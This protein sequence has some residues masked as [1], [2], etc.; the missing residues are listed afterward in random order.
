M[1]RRH[2]TVIHDTQDAEAIGRVLDGQPHPMTPCGEHLLD[3][4]SPVGTPALARALDRNPPIVV[5]LETD[6]DPLVVVREQEDHVL[7]AEVAGRVGHLANEIVGVQAVGRQQHL[8]QC[9]TEPVVVLFFHLASLARLEQSVAFACHLR[10]SNSEAPDSLRCEAGMRAR[11]DD[12]NVG[13]KRGTS[14]SNRLRRGPLRSVWHWHQHST[15]C[16]PKRAPRRR[17]MATARSDCSASP[18]CSASAAWPASSVVTGTTTTGTT[19]SGNQASLADSR[20]TPS[21][22]TDDRE[23][24]SCRVG[25]R[26]AHDRRG[27][28]RRRLPST[29]TVGRSSVSPTGSTAGNLDDVTGATSPAAGDDSIVQGNQ[30]MQSSAVP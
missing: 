14:C 8:L 20:V 10:E 21:P 25:G 28:R 5:A 30:P 16:T 22:R 18:V 7:T 2:G 26:L 1:P 6:E 9:S 29:N 23:A 3:P 17:T 12:S 24:S 11:P 27:V 4:R 19:R 15:P 13:R